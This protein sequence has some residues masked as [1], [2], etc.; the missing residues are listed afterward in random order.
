MNNL[1]IVVTSRIESRTKTNLLKEYAEFLL[2]EKLVSSKDECMDNL[3]VLISTAMDNGDCDI[4]VM[5]EIQDY[6]SKKKIISKYLQQKTIAAK[7]VE[8][9]IEK[10]IEDISDNVELPRE[11]DQTVSAY[12]QCKKDFESAER[13]LIQVFEQDCEEIAD[14]F[15]S[16]YNKLFAKE[17]LNQ[18]KK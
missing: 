17:F 6:I 8:S 5:E 11:L 10:S 18:F 7:L 3:G 13:E 12:L 9:I 15:V 2:E 4:S 14:S 1:P 16:K